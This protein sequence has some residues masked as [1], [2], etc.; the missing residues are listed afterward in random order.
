[1]PEPG[2]PFSPRGDRDEIENGTAFAPAFDDDG[3]ITAVV[4]DAGSGEVLMVAYMDREALRRTIATR[5]AWFWS[6]SRARHWRKGEDSGNTLTVTEVRTDC[7]QDV[8]LVKA[9]IAGDAVACHQGYRSCF[10]RTVP[11]GD[12]DGPLSLDLDRSMPRRRSPA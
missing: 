1:M 11:L 3:L 5:E 8:I 6:R 4:T 10:Y 9:T 12:A 7:D 2:S